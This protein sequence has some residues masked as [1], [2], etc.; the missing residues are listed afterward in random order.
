LDNPSSY[1]RLVRKLNYLM[2]TRLDIV[3]AVSV[4][5]QFLSAPKTSHWNAVRILRYL[6]KAL[7]KRLLYSDCDHTRVAGFQMHTGLAHLLIVDQSRATVYLLGK[8]LCR[9]EVKNKVWY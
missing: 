3:F 5:N 4:V 2:I 8:I 9:G 7:E 1:R 6:K